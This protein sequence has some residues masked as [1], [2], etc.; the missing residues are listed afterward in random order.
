MIL[1]SVIPAQAGTHIP[2]APLTKSMSPG[3]NAGAELL[4]NLSYFWVKA[5]VIFYLSSVLPIGGRAHFH[6]ATHSPGVLFF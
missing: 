5:F 2:E 1:P 4:I 3:Y 6:E